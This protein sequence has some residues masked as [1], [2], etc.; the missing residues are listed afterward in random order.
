MFEFSKGK[1][2]KFLNLVLIFP[3]SS[4]I[5]FCSFVSRRSFAQRTG[6]PWLAVRPVDRRSHS[7]WY[8]CTGADNVLAPGEC[9]ARTYANIK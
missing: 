2:F 3:S 5:W 6:Y 8:N 9:Y 7:R 4:G 1:L